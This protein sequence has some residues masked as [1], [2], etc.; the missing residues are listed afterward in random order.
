MAKNTK[1]IISERRNMN[2][3][4]LLF[5]KSSFSNESRPKNTNQKCLGRNC[6]TCEIMN[7]EEKIH[8]NNYKINLDFRLNC[9]TVNTIYLYVCKHCTEKEGFY[10]G[11]T[12]MSCNRRATGH[13][14]CFSLMQDKNDKLNREKYKL[15]ALSYHIYDKHNKYFED[16]LK[17]FKMGIIKQTSPH[18]LEK[19]ED[20]YIRNTKADICGLNRYKVMQ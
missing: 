17:N 12:T 5:G 4:S 20:L 7:L 18:N 13:R 10:I 16:G 2:T 3:A 15:S 8:I 9:N 14:A 6:K 19:L 1:I 11:K